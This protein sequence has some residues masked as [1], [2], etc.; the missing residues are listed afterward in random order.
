MKTWAIEVAT[1][2]PRGRWIDCGNISAVT[3]EDALEAAYA[4]ANG[5]RAKG[6]LFAGSYTCRLVA[7]Q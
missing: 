4:A 7:P 1:H 5:R 6:E 2:G 3:F